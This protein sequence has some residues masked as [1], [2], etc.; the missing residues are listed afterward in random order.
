MLILLDPNSGVPTYRQLVDQIRFQM[1]SGRLAAGSEL[2][3]TRALS[4][5]LG[6]N[7]MTVSKA[8]SLLEAEGLVRR[9]PGL[10]LE[11]SALSG[12]DADAERD[13]QLRV[14]LEPA[15]LAARQLGMRPAKAVAVFR[16]LLSDIVDYEE[17]D[18]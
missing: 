3:S 15:A 11:V 5:E 14:L 10:P 2:P 6:I 13:E 1:A 4:Q 9:R 7:P 17:R 8:Y 12:P 18:Q 16:Q